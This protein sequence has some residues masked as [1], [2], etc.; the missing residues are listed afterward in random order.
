MKRLN[1]IVFVVILGLCSNYAFAD[2]WLGTVNV[3]PTAKASGGCESARTS[4]DMSLNNV[5]AR[6]HTGGDMWW[7][8]QGKAKYEVPRGGG[9]HS[10]YCSAIWVGGK[11]A[12]GQLKLAAQRYRQGVK[13]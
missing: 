4:T 6:V 5:I 9:V 12:N 13:Q 10:L 2:K 3:T 7:D 1:K 8:L 11:D